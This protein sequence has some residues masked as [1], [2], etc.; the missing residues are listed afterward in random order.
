[1]RSRI[2]VR[3]SMIVIT[4]FDNVSVV[5]GGAAIRIAAGTVV[6]AGGGGAITSTKPRLSNDVQD[7]EK[8]KNAQ[9]T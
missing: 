9:N 3:S 7:S 6:V 2:C 1:M 4:T 5:V 8:S